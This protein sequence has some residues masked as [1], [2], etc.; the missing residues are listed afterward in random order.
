MHQ[1]SSGEAGSEDTVNR[2]AN[3][4]KDVDASIDD[5]YIYAAHVLKA[6]QDT[7]CRKMDAFAERPQTFSQ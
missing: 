2:V 4:R 3:A 7:F 1:I 5:L 6:V